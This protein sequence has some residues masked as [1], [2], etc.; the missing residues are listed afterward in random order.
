MSMHE[1]VAAFGDA[2]RANGL[3]VEHVEADG[4]IHR[5]G[6]E[7]EKASKRNAWYIL[8]AGTIPAGCFG[9]WSTGQTHRWRAVG[10]TLLTEEENAQIDVQLAEAK[11]LREVEQL[12]AQERAWQIWSESTAVDPTHAYLAAKRVLPHGIR[13]RNGLLVIPMRDAAG[14]LRSIQTITAD[15]TKRFLKGGRKKG[16]YFS[17][18]G[19]VITSLAICEGYAT[20]ATIH[21]ASNAPVAIAFDAG[22][23]EPVAIALRA[24]YPR[25]IIIVCADDDRATHDRIGRNPGLEAAKRAAKTIGG[26]LALP[27]FA[28]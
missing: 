13:Q 16:C 3:I 8:F 18:G 2:M 27:E 11:R 23:L 15:G 7:G 10:E 1:A 25:A 12:S 5:V 24:K 26:R 21:E 9:S 17:F 20:G 22:N 14:E 6:V 4:Q 28:R 19:P